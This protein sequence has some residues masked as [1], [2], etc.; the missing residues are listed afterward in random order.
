MDKFLVLLLEVACG[1]SGGN[2]LRMNLQAACLVRLGNVLMESSEFL[3]KAIYID[4][5]YCATKY[6]FF[7]MAGVR[8]P[9]PLSMKQRALGHFGVVGPPCDSTTHLGRSSTATNSWPPRL[10]IPSRLVP[11]SNTFLSFTTISSSTSPLFSPQ[12]VILLRRR[13]P[14]LITS[15]PLTASRL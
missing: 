15:S 7:Q 5:K 8:A 10:S 14:P 4:N 1:H 12:N 11:P 3:I 9:Q 2:L 6:T 13:R